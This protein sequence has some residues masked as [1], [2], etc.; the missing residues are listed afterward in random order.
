MC[1]LHVLC[2]PEVES[3]VNQGTSEP[4]PAHTHTFSH[5][6]IC[7]HKLTFLSSVS[8]LS[9]SFIFPPSL[10]TLSPSPT[11]LL[12]PP[13]LCHPPLSFIISPLKLYLSGS[14]LI[15]ALPFSPLP[16]SLSPLFLLL[17]YPPPSRM[18][19]F[20]A[21]SL[22]LDAHFIFSTIFL[23]CFT[24]FYRTFVY[25][26]YT[27]TIVLKLPTLFSIVTCHTGL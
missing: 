24:Y 12:S 3:R 7:A 17:I 20:T 5:T 18:P 8:L 1:C 21:C 10:I 4:T 11:V 23:L 19:P 22:S 16:S 2:P 13:S 9:F 27:N 14:L 26:K 25:F 6:H 15:S